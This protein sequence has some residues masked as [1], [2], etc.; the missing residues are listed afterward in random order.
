[1][2]G[3]YRDSTQAGFILLIEAAE[4]P[5]QSRRRGRQGAGTHTKVAGNLAEDDQG[6]EGDGKLIELHARAIS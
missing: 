4:R 6:D 3:T 1:M 2:E 5:C